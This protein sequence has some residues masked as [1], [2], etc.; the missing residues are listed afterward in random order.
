MLPNFVEEAGVEPTQS[1]H[2]HS[3]KGCCH[4]IRRFF[5]IADSAGSAPTFPESKSGIL[6]L[7][8][9]SILVIGYG[10]E[11]QLSDSESPFLPLE[12]P[13]IFV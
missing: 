13:I 10:F 12:E 6:L 1:F 9:E 5:N 11:P 4:A 3:F 7:D 2:S 8:D